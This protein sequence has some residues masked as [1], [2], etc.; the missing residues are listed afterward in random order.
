MCAPLGCGQTC[1]LSRRR[2]RPFTAQ[3]LNFGIVIAKGDFSTDGK[4]CFLIFE[5]TLADGYKP[6]WSRLK[7]QLE[8]CCPSEGSASLPEFFCG[9]A[10]PASQLF[11]LQIQTSD[12]PGVLHRL[13]S[14]VWE[15]DLS[16]H[17]AH[18][19]TN[20]G[21]VAID[22]FWVTDNT[23][24]LPSLERML[25]IRESVVGVLGE[26]A[27]C[28]IEPAPEGA[29]DLDARAVRGV[30]CK[31]ARAQDPL[32][33]HKAPPL[34]SRADARR[35]HRRGVSSEVTQ[36]VGLVG[37]DSVELVLD[38]TMSPDHTVISL[39]VPDR[40]GLTYDIMRV[41]KD[42]E[43][44]IAYGRIIP[45]DL[46][47]GRTCVDLFLQQEFENAAIC[48]GD[49][50][51]D[52]A[53]TLRFAIALPITITISDVFD[54]ACTQLTL[55]ASVD[56]G[57][58]GRPRVIFD[59]TRGIAACRC[60]IFMA[61]MFMEELP[62]DTLDTL[63]GVGPPAMSGASRRVEVH[64]F[65]VHDDSGQPLRSRE[66]KQQL[67]AHVKDQILGSGD[68]SK[69]PP[70]TCP[71]EAHLRLH[72]MNSF[73]SL[74]SVEGAQ[75]LS[76]A[77]KG[78]LR[79][80]LGSA[81]YLLKM[82]GADSI[83]EDDSEGEVKDGAPVADGPGTSNTTP[84]RRA[85]DAPAVHRSGDGTGPNSGV[86]TEEQGRGQYRAGQAPGEVAESNNGGDWLLGAA[87]RH[88]AYV[89]RIESGAPK[90]VHDRDPA[91]SDL[92]VEVPG[93]DALSSHHEVT[94]GLSTD[95]G[96]PRFYI[97][98]DE[99]TSPS[100]L[101][102]GGGY[103]RAAQVID[104]ATSVPGAEEEPAWD[105][106]IVSR[107]KLGGAD[108]DLTGGE[109]L[110]GQG[111]RGS[112]VKG[113]GATD[114][115]TSAMVETQGGADQANAGGLSRLPW[116]EGQ[117]CAAPAEVGGSEGQ[118]GHKEDLSDKQTSLSKIGAGAV[119]ATS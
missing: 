105:G 51:S 41:L 31:D 4:W 116:L 64:R 118:E 48:D 115:S 1:R 15:C 44:R 50:L 81:W 38:N 84:S 37:L 93:C 19:T 60:G 67:L 10:L 102:Q 16:V 89:P 95:T 103:L 74:A 20:P 11:V 80:Y 110:G 30:A 90:P 33:L 43:V 82:G 62:L 104:S 83:L 34:G 12:R 23:Y 68:L 77:A 7:R 57:G 28:V 75:G 111:F 96:M 18:I 5:V 8:R 73:D 39:S 42:Q 69:V 100:H 14:T 63:E 99:L 32:R 29:S 54:G 78:G 106:R 27:V 24:Q 71:T 3:M 40:K 92:S 9:R 59:T 91:R 13:V 94:D 25:K 88:Q 107:R 108:G 72:S 70:P 101:V 61:D 117:A 17:K 97:D 46:N 114:A 2:L 76:S 49:L 98:H 65:L 86:G 52:L 35:Q 109:T 113:T 66:Q 112:G 87:G 6:Y 79:H 36:V 26:S 21:D 119:L 56:S 58:R 22:M 45:D 53:D 85:H 55:R 47:P